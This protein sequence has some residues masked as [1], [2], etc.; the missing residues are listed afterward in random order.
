LDFCPIIKNKKGGAKMGDDINDNNEEFSTDQVMMVKEFAEALYW[1]LDEY[2]TQGYYTP[3]TQNQNLLSLNSGGIAPDYEAL[4]NALTNAV[5]NAYQLQNYSEYM[6]SWDTIYKKTLDIYDGIL[7]FDLSYSC[8]NY[9]DPS[10]FNSKEYKEDLNRVFKF[11]DKFDYKREFRKAVWYMNRRQFFP[12]WFRDST[13]TITESEIDLKLSEKKMAKYALQ[14]MPAKYCLITDYSP[15][16]ILYDFDMSYFLNPSI[17]INLYDPSFKR[18][19][20]EVYSEEYT[21]NYRPSSQYG[22]RDGRFANY[23]Q[24]SPDDGM[25]SFKFEESTF[26][27]TPP[28]SSLMKSVF[29][30]TKIQELQMDKNF[31]S[32]MSLIYGE[33]RTFN[34]Q[35]NNKPDQFSISPGAVGHFMNLVKSALDKNFKE[36]A[37]PL[38]NTKAWQFE[39]K[40]P[41][42]VGTALENS[43]G[44]GAFGSSLVFSSG[45]KGQAEV[46]NGI[47]ADYNVMKKTYSQFNSFLNFFVNKKTRTYKFNFKF[48]GCSYPFE[49]EYRRKQINEL[50]DRGLT[51]PVQAWASAYGFEP[52]DFNRMLD[53][54]VHGGMDKKLM[55]LLNAN[56]SKD[57]G[58]VGNPIKDQTSLSDA[59]G[60]SRDYK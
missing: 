28:F 39:D 44:Q 5:E 53:E 17:D 51:L 9:K 36:V 33:L 16:T 3:F 18:K 56:T 8:I 11:F 29:N 47:I 27:T 22:N 10:E 43:A 14:T 23:I 49:R 7:S 4:K 1:G 15:E 21:T 12:C 35:D 30:N 34:R 20:K 45:K 46:L 32:A 25:W 59:G 58:Q 31:K 6:A 57:G 2:R 55:L 37:L 26:D 13:G 52:H 60:V 48:D 54:A 24:M 38:E 42:M 40:V 19:F 41:N 50:A